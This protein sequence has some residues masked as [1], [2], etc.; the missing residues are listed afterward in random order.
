V[1]RRSATG[2]R[3]PATGN[4]QPVTGDRTNYIFS[5]SLQPSAFFSILHN[6]D[7]TIFIVTQIF[8]NK[9]DYFFSQVKKLRPN[10]LNNLF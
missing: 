5:S 7:M 9:N 10:P 3:Q 8:F 1:F 4:R 2:N 6:K